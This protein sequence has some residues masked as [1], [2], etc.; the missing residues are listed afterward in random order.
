MDNG[1]DPGRDEYPSNGDR[2]RRTLLNGTHGVSIYHDHLEVVRLDN[3]SSQERQLEQP[4]STRGIV[5]PLAAIGQNW[6][7]VSCGTAVCIYDLRN[8]DPV[9][10]FSG[11]GRVAT[12]F[13]WHPQQIT[14]L[15]VGY[16]D[17]S[18]IVWDVK[19]SGRAHR[20]FRSTRG[21]CDRIAFKPGNQEIFATSHGCSVVIWS[22]RHGQQMSITGTGAAR[23]HSTLLAWQPGENADLLAVLLGDALRLY[24]IG[25]SAGDNHHI[26]DDSSQ[27]SADH[28]EATLP[29][30]VT[31]L[32]ATVSYLQWVSSNTILVQHQ[33]QVLLF[34]YV[35]HETSV[36]SIWTCDLQSSTS[37]VHLH[38][39][40]DTA[41]LL[42]YDE[43]T[44]KTYDL[45]ADLVA[46]LTSNGPAEVVTNLDGDYPQMGAVA[47]NKPK[48]SGLHAVVPSGRASMRPVPII[49][50]MMG[51]STLLRTSIQLQRRKAR[52]SR[53]STA[54]PQE[55]IEIEGAETPPQIRSM[56]SSLELP[57][58]NGSDHNSSP[59][60]FLSPS[61]PA[62]NSP[63]T[64]IAPLDESVLELPPLPESFNTAATPLT[65]LDDD[66][67]SDDEAFVD[68]LQGSATFLPGGIHVPLPKACGALFAPNGQLLTFFPP[69]TAAAVVQQDVAISS[70]N[71]QPRPQT[72]ANKTTRLFSTFGNLIGDAFVYLTD[73]ESDSSAESFEG[74]GDQIQW[75]D[76]PIQP[77]SFQ[78][79][80][81]WQARISPIKASFGSPQTSNKINIRIY[82][83]DEASI[84]VN[85][86]QSL[87]Q[88][89]RYLRGQDESGADLCEHNASVA[90][91]A[92]LH[93]I[94]HIYSLLAML[95]EDRVPLQAI[96]E[97]ARSV[98]VVA[99]RA[100]ALREQ[101][102]VLSCRGVE[103]HG[104]LFGH[105]RWAEDAFSRLWLVRAIFDWAERSA[106]V[107][108]LASFAA[109][110]AGVDQ[111]VRA[112]EP[113]IK[114]T[115]SAKLASYSVDYELDEYSPPSFTRRSS[116]PIPMLQPPST[117]VSLPV[118][119]ESPTKQNRPSNAS[120]RNASQPTTPHVESS[121]TTPP[122][123]LPSLSRQ[124]SRL[125]A[126]GSASPETNRS[127]FSAAA[128]SYAQS[129]TDKFSSY[130]AYGTS[131]PTRRA[132]AS[133]SPG[134]NELSTSLPSGSWTKSVSFAASST[135]AVTNRGS[136][137]SRSFDEQYVEDAYDSDKT[138]E[139][140][141]LPQ[142]PRSGI[143][144]ILV[145]HKNHGLFDDEFSGGAKAPLLPDEVAVKAQLWV[146][147]Y[148]EQ[149]R[150]WG[151]W[152]KA[153]ELEKIMGI[154]GPDLAHMDPSGGE[155]DYIQ[156]VALK[157][158]AQSGICVICT[159]K[160]LSTEVLCPVCLHTSHITCFTEYS[161]ALDDEEF[162]CPAGCDCVC[163]KL[164]Y[165]VA[166]AS[167][168]SPE[169]P[170]FR[171]KASFTDP[172]RWRARIEGDDWDRAF[173]APSL[174]AADTSYYGSPA[175]IPGILN[176][177]NR[178]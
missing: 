153:A 52:L 81:S 10:T 172:M 22:L 68:R 82:A 65:R 90:D 12:A 26:S 168:P 98:L 70:S 71:Q 150:T 136:L 13:G 162:R 15:T 104:G 131:P 77:S 17:G 39:G 96:S 73:S 1:T 24:K 145:V 121:S 85:T 160:L 6:L 20:Q 105:L 74:T 75:T 125:S 58:P 116:R 76:I 167:A 155:H 156:P 97:D 72:G 40:E 29:I 28:D 51:P 169:R 35:E 34:D 134:N 99:R 109:I 144:E 30:S 93:D 16:I 173:S 45:P 57:K 31:K 92:G 120:S 32:S 49:S 86:Q 129:I 21:A 56:N 53:T 111:S 78:S 89:Y 152:L 48:I 141:S 59:M 130:T 128:K 9:C 94:S 43:G 67:D 50:E 66:D 124:E 176:T 88:G 69:K 133:V 4:L 163:P 64:V 143:G 110:L 178:L 174:S 5:S 102:E 14:C 101:D 80:R 19:K 135:T 148:A 83:L 159:T 3:P 126:S 2:P 123:S 114:D 87:A 8:L 38:I 166:E 164:P 54:R 117:K 63:Q 33:D 60:P 37:E 113:I 91:A 18:V 157:I 137:L 140:N 55:R 36:V 62:R 147:Y 115:F 23:D 154:T 142:T 42:A 139:D 103:P 161:A 118:L 25:S 41:R 138:V 175:T 132:G 107:Q 44:V 112:T 47:F 7:V 158:T 127:S 46:R 79:H 170:L 149:L 84:A 119:H 171:K 100:I 27:S 61:I 177:L 151:L 108:H 106:D 165:V 122:F 95:M 11:A 146:Q